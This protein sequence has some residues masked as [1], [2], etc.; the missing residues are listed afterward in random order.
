[1]TR[2]YE[3]PFGPRPAVADWL[4]ANDIDPN[5]V[6]IEGPITIEHG[7]IHYAA[8]LRN[9]AGHLYRDS[10][11]DS[12]AREERTAQLK[13]KPPENVQVTSSN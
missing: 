3:T 13:A 6:P 7:R 8:L 5:D 12:A 10:S 11:T 1:M 9:E 2:D 4:R